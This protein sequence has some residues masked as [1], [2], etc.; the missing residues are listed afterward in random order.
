MWKNNPQNGRKIF[1]NHIPDKEL[2]F[3]IHK[4]LLKLGNKK[5]SFKNHTKNI[6]TSPNTQMP[7]MH[8]NY[9]HEKMLNIII[10]WKNMNQN[11]SEIPFHIS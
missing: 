2:V 6:D 9:V 10:H 4:Q 1:A 3:Q 11:H 7:N 5:P 8:M